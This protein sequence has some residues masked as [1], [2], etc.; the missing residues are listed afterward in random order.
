MTAAIAA[1][2]SAFDEGAANGSGVSG[3]CFV[4]NLLMR[5]VEM[6]IRMRNA[7]TTPIP[8]II[9]STPITSSFDIVES[10]ML[11]EVVPDARNRIKSRILYPKW[12]EDARKLSCRGKASDLILWVSKKAKIQKPNKRKKTKIGNVKETIHKPW[13]G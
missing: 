13:V 1:P 10:L 5:F 12:A 3:K 8:I 11:K 2:S 4:K 6:T 7:K 9:H